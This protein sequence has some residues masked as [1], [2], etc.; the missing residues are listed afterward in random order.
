[1][2]GPASIPV[3]RCSARPWLPWIHAYLQKRRRPLAEAHMPV[4]LRAG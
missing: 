4:R 2:N 3:Y 1:M